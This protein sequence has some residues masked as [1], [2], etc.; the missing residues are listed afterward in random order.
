[1][2]RESAPKDRTADVL[3]IG[4]GASGLAAGRALRRAGLRVLVLE[5]RP[6]IGGRVATERLPGW[7]TVVE[8]GAEFVHGRPPSLLR[9]IRAARLTLRDFPQR[10][11]WGSKGVLRS[12]EDLW[13]KAFDVLERVA[14]PERPVA[15]V[16][17]EA[18]MRGVASEVLAIAR[19][20][21][22]G[23]NAADIDRL[24]ARSLAE[25]N[26]AEQDVESD[27]LGRLPG[28]YD[29]VPS[30]LA[31]GLSRESGELHL[32]AV[33]KE[34]RWR[35]GA[36]EILARSREGVA[37]PSFAARA[38]LITVPL[39]VLQAAGRE[40]G[41]IRFVPPLPRE[42][43]SAIDGL[44]M[45]TV[46]KTTFRFRRPFWREAGRRASAAMGE[47]SFLHLDRGEPPT[48]WVVPFSPRPVLTGWIAGPAAAPLTDLPD[49]QIARRAQVTL[50]RAFALSRPELEDLLEDWRVWNW[51]SD[52]FA[53]G[54]YSYVLVGHMGAREALARSVAG[55]L[56]FAG[57]AVGTDGHSGTVH[58]ALDSGQ[59]AA[60]SI[61]AQLEP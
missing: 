55:T 17:R 22:E 39:G 43:A 6:R 5:A 49:E 50:A 4:A 54:A 20:Y 2:P 28:G 48:F 32:N 45:G 34:L 3:I 29:A 41:A 57:E 11:W 27:K 26:Q 15:E 47:L 61:L 8:G 24:S 53:R 30:W 9:I 23:F 56:F 37:L 1:M 12:A 44:A 33:V 51:W 21:V 18:S 60:R 13:P 52:P 14:G 42:A 36:V 35:P 10:H 19:G 25:Q 38:A 58:G 7:E 40:P 46:V 31:R 59:R 16:L